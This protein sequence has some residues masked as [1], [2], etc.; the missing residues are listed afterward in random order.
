MRVSYSQ[1]KPTSLRTCCDQPT[2]RT[3]EPWSHHDPISFCFHQLSR[4]VNGCHTQA[5]GICFVSCSIVQHRS[6][7]E[8]DGPVL[9]PAALQAMNR[10]MHRLK[11][12]LSTAAEL[13]SEYHDSF[14]EVR[15]C[16]R[17][18]TYKGTESC[19]M[20]QILVLWSFMCCVC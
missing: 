1:P 14:K 20:L 5:T 12:L 18:K 16:F 8:W 6:T 2:E 11:V 17:N 9:C 15:C 4:V 19:C 7:V 10:R 3:S 13:S